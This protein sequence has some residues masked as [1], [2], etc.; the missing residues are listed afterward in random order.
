MTLIILIVAAVAYIYRSGLLIFEIMKTKTI[1]ELLTLSSTLY[2]LAK[3]HDL[4]DRIGE[5]S[6]KGKAHFNQIAHEDVLD[7]NGNEMEFVDK[8]IRKVY[9]A[10]DELEEKMEE[11]I[12]KFY[13]KINVAHIDEIDALNIKLEKSDKKI[14]LLEARLNHIEAKN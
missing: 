13:K 11:L 7:E 3:E 1:I 10:K 6:E 14:A 4:F 12:V 9:Q 8:F 2:V 5:M